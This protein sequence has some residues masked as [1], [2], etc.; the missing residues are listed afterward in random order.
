MIESVNNNTRQDLI[1][2][3]EEVEKELE[4]LDK[5]LWLQVDEKEHNKNRV[6]G[7]IGMKTFLLG[8]LEMLHDELVHLGKDKW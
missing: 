1:T 7:K 6:A 3:I 8:K 5:T 4:A 2:Q